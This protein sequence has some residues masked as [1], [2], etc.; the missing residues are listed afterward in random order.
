MTVSRGTSG[1]AATALTVAGLRA[2]V[3]VSRE[4]GE[5]LTA[6]AELLVKW[7]T[8]INLIGP[9]TLPDLWRR[10]MLDSA[11]LLPRLRPG[12]VLDMGSGA[13]FPGMVL[14]IL[15][16]DGGVDPVHLVE[17]DSRK[18]AF[19]REVAR[20]TQAPA[21]VHNKRLEQLN[22][23]FVKTITARALAPLSKLLDMAEPFLSPDTECLF[24]K[25]K[26]GED[27]LTEGSKDWMMLVERIA[28]LADPSGIILHLREVHR[29]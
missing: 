29:G 27:E 22:P 11:Q 16:S 12:P 26:G 6:Y 2:L 17:S 1:A 18:C 23:F 8:R 24:L 10:H 21:V 4:T 15:R 14:A 7:Q 25:G 9:A 20:V 5:R 19:L 13:G 3:P 28:S